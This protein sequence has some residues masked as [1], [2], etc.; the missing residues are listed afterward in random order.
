V[1]TQL[2]RVLMNQRA[3]CDES[4]I[5]TNVAEIVIKPLTPEL[6]QVRTRI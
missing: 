3:T 6:K 5:S 4:E 1:Y 2:L